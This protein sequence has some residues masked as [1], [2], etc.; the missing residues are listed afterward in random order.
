MRRVVLMTLVF[1]T[2]VA[3]G[4]FAC[5][6]GGSSNK[7][8]AKIEPASVA[9]PP[10]STPELACEQA[11]P[12]SAQA[13]LL[14]GRTVTHERSCADGVCFADTCTYRRDARD[15]G[16]QVLYDC[17]GGNDGDIRQRDYFSTARKN[18]RSVS[19]LGAQAAIDD[20][21]LSFYDA[22]ASCL[23]TIR[24]D[25]DEQD[26]LELAQV[27]ESNLRARVVTSR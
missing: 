27:I 14:P 12:P 11:L 2:G 6:S 4:A 3:L 1:G 9:Q 23:V 18:A 10:G 22:D 13:R 26:Y 24:S 7:S 15:H 8:K 19:G 20:E 17:R 21:G 16:V 5:S 25:G